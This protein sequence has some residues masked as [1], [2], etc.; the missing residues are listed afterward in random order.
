M[1]MTPV[2]EGEVV[3]E[4]TSRAAIAYQTGDETDPAEPTE[5]EADEIDFVHLAVHSEFSL[6]DGLAKVKDLTARTASLG[7]PALALT[8][9]GNLF[10]LV[11]FYSACRE[12][13]IKAII[14]VD[15]DFEDVDGAYR[16]TVLVAAETGYRNL[17]RLVSGAYVNAAD[18]AGA[19][20]A[21]PQ[22]GRI[23]RQ[24]LLAAGNGLIVL[25]GRES[26]IGAAMGN[27]EAAAKR[28]RSWRQAFGDR[29]YLQVTRTGR[30]GEGEFIGNAVALAAAEG[31]PVV[32]TN[33]VRF[34][35][36]D[37]FE[38]H[39]ARVCI[40]EGRVLNDPRRQRRYSEQQYL[41]SAAEMRDLFA[42]LPEALR[43]TV[44]IAKRCSYAMKLGKYHLPSYPL[45]DG[46][47]LESVLEERSR[48]GLADYLKTLPDA[49]EQRY[50]ERLDYELGIIKEMDFAGY[51]LI[52][53][54]FV[55]WGRQHNVPVG[56][57]GSGNASLVAYCLGITELD[58][59]QYDLL[60]ERLL[61][62]ERVSMPD[63]DIDFCMEGR[64]R[65]IAHVAERY[66][67]D[68]VGLIVTFGTMA[69]RQVVRDVAR[70]QDKPYGLAE[71]LAK[72]IPKDVGMTLT[73][74][75]DQEETLADFVKRD[76]D[77]AEIMDMAY[78]LEGVVRNTGKHAGGVVIA[79]TTLTDFVPLYSDQ[80]GGA[81]VSQFDL[82]DVE[83]AGLVK[84]DL[85]GLKTLTV[86]DWALAAA[87]AE[88]E[89]AG[90]EPIDIKA[91]PLD[92]PATYEFLK[93]A[94]TKAVFQLESRGMKDLI[95][96]L[97]PD[98]IDD[99]I[100]LVALFRPGPLQSGAVDDYVDRKHG[101]A[102]VEYP[103]PSLEPA[104]D[105]TYGVILYQE[106]VMNIG[107]LLAGF[108]LGQ[109]DLLRRAMAKKKPEEM[110]EM[111]AMFLAGTDANGVNRRLAS[112]LFDQVEK[113]AGYAFNKAHAAAYAV[114]AFQTAW[115]KLNYPAQFMAAALSADMHVIE[116]VVELVDEARRMKL[117]V[118]PP[119]VNTS[120]YRFTATGSEV[121]YG[122][123]AVRGVGEGPVAAIVAERERGGAFKD[124]NDFCLR[125]DAKRMNR[126][127]HEALIRSGAMDG[128]AKPGEGIEHLRA[129]LLDELPDAL[130][131]A[132]QVARDTQLGI[133]DMFGGAA[134]ASAKEAAPARETRPL[135][136]PALLEGEKET[137]GLYLNGHPVEEHLEEIRRF[138]R[139]EIGNLRV[140]SGPQ[141]VAGIVIKHRTL[142]GRRGEMAF[143][144]L[145]DRSGRIDANIFGEVFRDNRN[146]LKPDAILI[147][148]GEVQ[149]DDFNGQ[150]DL[151]LR[152]DSVMTL[153]EARARH[154]GRIKVRVAEDHATNGN[155]AAQGGGA[156]QGNGVTNGNGATNGNGVTNGNGG[157]GNGSAAS[158]GFAADLKRILSQHRSEQGCPVIVDY[159][160][161]SAHGRIAL[162]KAWRAD[163]SDALLGQLRERFGASAVAV[164]YD[165]S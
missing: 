44:E 45:P 13:G 64:E 7:M 164:S 156:V 21:A 78:K 81:V 77:A 4:Q 43:N 161:G 144:T 133:D 52:V 108:S 89:A 98:S 162:G 140:A 65:V 20:N 135:S 127:V 85:L 30:R 22:H 3:A 32:A 125:T 33:D 66:G 105:S 61:N 96:R 70:V 69:A 82:H 86:I 16:C 121:L 163:A 158:N 107:R 79:P 51:F 94:E 150:S 124:L 91:V 48:T 131:G 1:T 9:R 154:A 109:A 100:A 29:V 27:R 102:R 59:L 149:N 141:T 128:F 146:K 5:P 19:T 147:I 123:G 62:P 111:R 83:E 34:L 99:I 23:S 74:A 138:C 136:K 115:L 106:Q 11:K 10:G 36:R 120:V 39:E 110:V 53:Q 46:E 151:K 14:G 139:Q 50:R 116:D 130:Q 54:E 143:T 15:L 129:R 17:L 142:R 76:E 75:I 145:D 40:Q 73:K 47:T 63:F 101:R 42:D 18:D 126:R 152:A 84:F 71:R 38:A 25:L 37:D 114:L 157:A 80:S 97:L 67:F 112:D 41:R 165:R 55:N 103:H 68:A 134:S 31:V 87:N 92:E 118:R 8:D 90:E 49:N 113:F 58:P 153:A 12:A 88:R 6:A 104:L 119:D 137:L 72:M 26:D 132:E 160:T 148:Q 56:C 28:L 155:S 60:F 95:R 122:L 35:S 2:A 117:E 93:K 24:A 57:R 159:Q